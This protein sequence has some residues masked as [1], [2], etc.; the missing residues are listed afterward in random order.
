[1]VLKGGTTHS[2]SNTTSY[3]ILYMFEPHGFVF[4]ESCCAL[5]QW[6]LLNVMNLNSLAQAVPITGLLLKFNAACL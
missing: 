4:L 2:G 6:Q 3:Y 5:R 1:M